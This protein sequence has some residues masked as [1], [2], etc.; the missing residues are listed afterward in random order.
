MKRHA[1][2]IAAT[3]SVAAIFL[4]ASC[5]NSAQEIQDVAE[6]GDL[7]PLN[8]Q[9]NVVYEYSDS[10]Q[11]RLEITSPEVLDFSHAEEPYMEF[12]QGITVTFFNKLGQPESNLKANYAKRLIDEQRWDARGDVVVLNKKGEQLNTEHLVWERVNHRIHSNVF[13]KIKAGDEVM[14]GDG[15]EADENFESYQLKGNV[16]GELKIDEKLDTNENVENR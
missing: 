10:A 12:P 1:Y 3:L 16:R 13:T 11:K 7:K 15:F 14:M 5:T 8:T 2:K 4:F 6:K 9:Q